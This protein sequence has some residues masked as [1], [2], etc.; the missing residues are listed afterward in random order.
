MGLAGK[1][2][3]AFGAYEIGVGV[4]ANLENHAYWKLAREHCDK[5]DKPLLLIGMRRAWKV[6]LGMPNGDVT[7]DLDPAVQSIKGGVLADERDMPFADKQFGACLNEHTL[8]HLHS[9]EDVQLAVNECF[10]V[11]DKAIFTGPSPYSVFNNFF[12]PSHYLRLWF[13]PVNNKIMVV[14]NVYRTG[15]GFSSGIGQALVAEGNAPIVIS[16]K[17]KFIV[18]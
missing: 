2:L 15:W 4:R 10:R 16:S 5:V 13:D 11:A 7:L 9:A 12:L 6:A 1:I 14:E 8:E 3:L 17:G 18:W